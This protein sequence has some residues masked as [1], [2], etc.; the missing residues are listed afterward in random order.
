[1]PPAKGTRSTSRLD[2]SFANQHASAAKKSFP[3]LRLPYDIRDIIYKL[4]LKNPGEPIHPDSIG[5][6]TRTAHH[7][8]RHFPK[9][10]SFNPVILA[11]CRQIHE[12]ASPTLYSSNVFKFSSRS[13]IARC[14]GCLPNCDC[15]Q[16]NGLTIL[17]PWLW[18][19][20][21]YNRRLIRQMVMHIMNPDYLYYGGEHRLELADHP[22]NGTVN[23]WKNASLVWEMPFVLTQLGVLSVNNRAI[24]GN[25]IGP[26]LGRAFA[27]LARGHGLD[28]ISFSFEGYY[29]DALAESLFF[30]GPDSGL[31]RELS[32]IKGI[33]EL[34]VE[35]TPKPAKFLGALEV[36][37]ARME[38]KSDDAEREV[39]EG[40][41]KAWQLA[42]LDTGK[43]QQL[44]DRVDEAWGTDQ[45]PDLSDV[46]KVGQLEDRVAVLEEQNRQLMAALQE[47]VLCRNRN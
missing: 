5:P 23:G 36:V 9:G 45:E 35:P 18:L 47:C 34:K 42:L 32:Q 41:G 31:L 3:F 17:N 13:Q 43:V 39:A 19:I 15:I 21:P 30:N 2:V 11:T 24:A 22:R 4:M 46:E 7:D 27:L 16:D 28:R 14:F 37:K 26:Y 6:K 12:E 40:S 33:K 8:H 29:A 1:M 44:E 10:F 20:G 25:P 38:T